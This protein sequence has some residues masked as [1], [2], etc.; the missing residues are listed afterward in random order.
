MFYISE[1][2]WQSLEIKITNNKLKNFF[3]DINNTF[4]IK[5]ENE[6]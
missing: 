3:I 1:G 6:N 4:T 5:I 2:K